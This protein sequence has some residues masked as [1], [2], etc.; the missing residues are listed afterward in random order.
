MKNHH[1]SKVRRCYAALICLLV[2]LTVLGPAPASA[3]NMWFSNNSTYSASDIW[4]TV[5]RGQASG[6]AQGGIAAG[7]VISSQYVPDIGYWNGAASTNLNWRWAVNSTNPLVSPWQPG[8]AGSIYSESLQLSYI[9]TNGMGF[10]NWISNAASA[11]VIVSYGSPFSPYTPTNTS[12][13]SSNNY[14]ASGASANNTS[15]PNYR[16]AWQPFEITYNPGN[17]DQ[18]NLTAINWFTA[19]L[20]IQSFESANATG[21]V[22]QE[23]GF[24][25]SG[26]SVGSALANITTATPPGPEGT[27]GG[28]AMVTNASGSVVR[29]IGPSQF[30]ATANGAWGYGNYQSFDSYFAG[31]GSS[32]AMFSNNSAYNTMSGTP[33][34]N[35]TNKNVSF[36]FNNSV[37]NT[38]NGYA[39]NPTG[40]ITVVTTAYT[41]NVPSG[42]STTNTYTGINFNVSPTAQGGNGASII[43]NIASQFV[44]LGSWTSFNGGIFTNSDGSPANYAWFEGTGWTDFSNSM[45]GFVTGGGANAV[46]DKAAQIAG[47]IATGFAAGFVGSTNPLIAG[48]PSDSWWTN[49]PA[50]AFAGA[51]TNT[52]DYNQYGAIIAEASSNTVY[53]MVYSDR[54]QP[55]P[56]INSVNLNGTNIGSWLITIEDPITAVPEPSTYA[57]LAMAGAG[58]GGYMLRR[59]RR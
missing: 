40:T 41:N 53:G 46:G 25:Q 15:D 42:P 55:T 57:L 21:S 31:A 43:T 38:G 4:I 5:Q 26:T 2:A 35:Y 19:S 47:E 51:T 33:S 22:L 11:A 20:K 13:P 9:Q 17:G 34:G 27:P 29:Y 10:L 8:A 58:L 7:D 30:G 14:A 49:S 32:N 28:P 50:N 23:G 12:V 45:T 54:W 48:Q 59:R 6:L 44:Y 1:S 3:L 18:G 36:A 16:N 37:T 56:L 24:Y 39:L 52:S